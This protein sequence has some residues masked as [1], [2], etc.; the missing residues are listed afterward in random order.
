LR[1][2]DFCILAGN[3]RRHPHPRRHLQ[4]LLDAFS[5]WSKSPQ[6]AQRGWNYPIQFRIELQVDQDIEIRSDLMN[7]IEIMQ[8]SEDICEL[9]II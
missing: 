2:R 6:A 8:H 9:K 1:T 3:S 5:S 7:T 4:L